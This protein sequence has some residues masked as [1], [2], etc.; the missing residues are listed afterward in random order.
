MEGPQQGR[1][2]SWSVIL[3]AILG[4]FAAYF[5]TRKAKDGEAHATVQSGVTAEKSAVTA[6]IARKADAQ[7]KAAANPASDDEL[8]AGLRQHK[9]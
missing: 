6:E 8:L 5:A 9:F 1:A 3:K 2:V 4:A 7:S